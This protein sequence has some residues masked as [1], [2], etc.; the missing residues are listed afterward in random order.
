MRRGEFLLHCR[1]QGFTDIQENNKFFWQE[2]KRALE[3]GKVVD[4]QTLRE[5]DQIFGL[6]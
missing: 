4:P 6:N 5:Y 3:E 1:S 2:I